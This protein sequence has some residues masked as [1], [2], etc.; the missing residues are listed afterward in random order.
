MPIYTVTN[1]LNTFAL[2]NKRVFLRVDFN[3]PLNNGVIV[4][5]Y[6]LQSSL[7]TIDYLLAKK[8]TLI[9]A[10]HIGRPEHPC[11]ALSTR[12]LKPWFYKRGYS[13]VYAAQINDVPSLLAQKPQLVLLENLRFFPSEQKEDLHF[14]QQLARLA[15]YYVIDAFGVLH[16]TDTSLRLTAQQFPIKRRSIGFLIERELYHLNRI[17]LPEKPY[18]I[19][20]G[21][22]KIAEKLSVLN[23]FLN[24]ATDL[25]V[26]PALVFTFLKALGIPIGTSL[27]D[28]TALNMCREFA[29]KVAQ[30]QTT[31]HIPSD[32]RVTTE[33]NTLSV[34]TTLGINQTGI[35]IGPKSEKELCDLIGKAK[36]IF[37]NGLMGFLDQPHTLIPV[38]TIFQAMA[39]SS[40]FSLIAGGDSVAAVRLFNLFDQISYCST[41]GGATLHYLA[42]D[43]LPGLE[44]FI[45]K[46]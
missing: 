25:F 30:S 18:L 15:D 40:G 9:L 20:M 19:I 35:T 41:G 37:Y 22:A 2:E 46:K 4:D 13:I 32:F 21:G 27:V 23:H 7:E 45:T 12:H 34:V 38:K 33:K 29:Q 5:D 43:T 14:A 26:G 28:E 1:I 44:P 8:A 16:R 36:T 42:G 24:Q 11:E 6:K 3:V 39:H 31:L 17:A 10:T